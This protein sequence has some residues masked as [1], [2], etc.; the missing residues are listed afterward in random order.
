MS[1]NS[2]RYTLAPSGIVL[3]GTSWCGDCRRARR[4]LAE[5]GVTYQDID[6]EADPRAARFVEEIN[7]GRRSVPTIVFPDG[8]LL[9]EPDNDSLREKLSA[10]VG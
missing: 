8:A 3:Y 10:A 1:E 4:I 6:I 7:H 5:L 9:V 2:N